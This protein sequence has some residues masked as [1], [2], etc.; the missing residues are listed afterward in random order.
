MQ[1]FW[2]FK[3]LKAL[4]N[5]VHNDVCIHNKS[6]ESCEFKIFKNHHFKIVKKSIK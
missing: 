3:A 5:E 4:G 6:L 1:S 2:N